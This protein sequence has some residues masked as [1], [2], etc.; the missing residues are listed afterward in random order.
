MRVVSLVLLM[1]AGALTASSATV[2]AQPAPAAKVQAA[3]TP[4]QGRYESSIA[5]SKQAMMSDPALALRQAR[6]AIA[7]A[8]ALPAAEA[9]IATA[10]GQWLEGEALMRLNRLAEAAPAIDAALVTVKR[11]ERNGK[12]HAN[13]IKSRALISAEAGDLQAALTALQES[14][15]LFGRLGEARSQSIVLQNIGSIY[16]EARDFPKV[17][18]YYEQANEAFTGDPNLT[19]A[20]HNNRGNAFK[21]MGNY[22]KA[23]EEFRLAL[24]GA[25]KMESPL[26]QV[27]V[28]TNI[29]S[30]Q[31][32][33][34]NLAEADR[35]A[36]AGLDMA[37][38][39]AAEW[40]PYLWGVRAQVAFKRGELERA[41]AML[42]RTFGGVDLATTT[43]PFRDFHETGFRIFERMGQHQLALEHLK[44]FKRLN[45]EARD[46]AASAQANLLSAQFDAANQALRISQLKSAKMADQLRLNETRNQLKSV[47]FVSLA[48][49]AAALVV[50]LAISFAFA[51]TRRNR[52]KLQEANQQLTYTANH[53]GLTQLANRTR[54]REALDEAIG[55]SFASGSRLDLF[56]L[57]LDRFKPV[58]DTMGHAAGDTIL[59][60]VAKRL[61]NLVG[62]G[63][64]AGRL[65]GDEFAVIY[66]APG[67]DWDPLSFAHEIVS[68]LSQP[69]EID[70][71]TVLI[72]ATVGIASLPADGNSVDGLLRSAD[73]ALYHAKSSGR[74]TAA[75]FSSAMAEEVDQRHALEIELR[76]AIVKGQLELEYQPMIDAADGAVVAKEALLRWRH[77]QHGLIAPSVF[78]PIAEESHLIGEI[79]KWVLREACA[80]AATWPQQVKLAVNL[81]AL[82]VEGSDIIG[83][84]IHSLANHGLQPDRLE[85]EVT[86]SIFVRQGTSTV[87]T[88]ASLNK[89]GI[90]LV[91]DDFGTG[92]SSL[93]YLQ[94]ASFS[95]IK[96]DRSFVVSAAQGHKESMSII[97]AIVGLA[98]G[99]GMATTAEGIET[100]EQMELMRELGCSQF[101]GYLFGEPEAATVSASAAASLEVAPRKPRRQRRAA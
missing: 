94:Q 27:R 39:E 20:S 79:G 86:E 95:K 96:I 35:I 91:L 17:L 101:Q 74:G 100:A 99:L 48:G 68:E 1:V 90:S 23:I 51:S 78:I 34:G 46:V 47:V 30:A 67:P 11:V 2:H 3:T 87:A 76:Q 88:L 83:Q 36:A 38:G 89:L 80:E 24:D 22:P 84:V 85:L 77:P 50:L 60:E 93:S 33:A 19:L 6:Q 52:I 12:L 40:A 81:S 69:Y 59:R 16:L 15:R 58:N 4:S 75:R 53:D 28:M 18:Q 25:R 14:H 26:L 72:G 9:D 29:A 32:L 41:R 10:N 66:T 82:Q 13:L 62:T 65:G 54:L 49:G 97:Q 98:Q 8:K 73:L 5:A 61:A 43:L 44:A 70:G 7:A 37:K 56:L 31:V 92:Y 64:L 63:G 55:D 45:D 57:D 42:E 21:E 71:A